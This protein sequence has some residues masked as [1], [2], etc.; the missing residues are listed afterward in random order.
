MKPIVIEV[1]GK[2]QAWKQIRDRSGQRFTAPE[3]RRWQNT[4]RILAGQQ[5]KGRPA[6]NGPVALVLVASILPSSSWA[7]W[8]IEAALAGRIEPTVTPDLSN[9]IKATED[10]LSTIVI[11][12]DKQVVRHQTAKRYARAW[13][14]RIEVVPLKAAAA[15]VKSRRAMEEMLG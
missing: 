12:D 4:V 7:A 6:L 10:A 8:K 11:E 5:M 3:V 9:Y 14:I 15:N 13:G 1:A 2:P